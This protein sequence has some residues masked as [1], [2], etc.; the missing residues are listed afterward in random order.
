MKVGIELQNRPSKP[1][2]QEFFFGSLQ[3]TRVDGFRG[4]KGLGWHEG[5]RVSDFGL[6]VAVAESYLLT[7]RYVKVERFEFRDAGFMV[8]PNPPGTYYIGP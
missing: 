6:R 2:G 7:R 1:F 3:G 4:C 5:C 8:S